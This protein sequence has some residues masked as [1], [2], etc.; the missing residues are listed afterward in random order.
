MTAAERLLAYRRTA[1][2]F[3]EGWASD[4]YR[5]MT[6]A[7]DTLSRET[8]A[9]AAVERSRA[10]RLFHMAEVRWRKEKTG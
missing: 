8:Y 6:A 9:T 7:Q 4:A 10:R 5:V 2:A 3:A 1:L